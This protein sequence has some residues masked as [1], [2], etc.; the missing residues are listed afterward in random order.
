MSFSRSDSSTAKFSPPQTQR[1][2]I[3][4][5]APVHDFL[6]AASG[7]SKEA[8]KD[9][10]E[11]GGIWL[12]RP[13]QGER[14][15]RQGKFGLRAGDRLALYY[16]A[17][18]LAMVVPPAACLCDQGRYSVWD[19]PAFMLSQGSRF[20]DHCSLLRQVEK[21]FSGKTIHLV[22]RLD[23]EAQGL[24][25]F[26]HNRQAA[27]AFSQL[28]QGRAVEKRYRARVAGRLAAVGET[29]R[30]D[31]PLDGKEAL[32]EVTVLSQDAATSLL[33]VRIDTGRL[34]QIRRHLASLGHPLLG[35]RRY[36]RH[37]GR[38]PLQLVAWL[39]AFTCP[40]SGE[41]KR[42]QLTPPECLSDD[43]TI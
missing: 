36:N 24:M 13:S 17:R 28:F 40:F 20:G 37:C 23:R 16:D 12:K 34:H 14:R 11:K 6:A 43:L 5:P 26:A 38:Q 22:H 3:A 35:D 32:T 29:M 19:K 30:I 42:Y 2:L 18:V 39:L 1:W 21:T 25:L 31:T 10:L 41:K 7:L 8:L 15:L 33:D 27:A 9:C 4:Q